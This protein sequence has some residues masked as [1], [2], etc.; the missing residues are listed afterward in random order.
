VSSSN[1]VDAATRAAD[2]DDAVTERGHRFLELVVGD[3]SA[4]LDG[5]QS[6]QRWPPGELDFA[7]DVE[8]NERLWGLEWLGHEWLRKI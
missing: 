4:N 6:L 3:L 1:Q 2:A 7:Q 8:R 5:H